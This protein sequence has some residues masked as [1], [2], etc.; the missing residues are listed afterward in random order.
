MNMDEKINKLNSLFIG[1][2]SKVNIVD[3]KKV[4]AVNFDNAATT[5]PF[6][7]VLESIIGLSDY[8]GSIGRGAG[9][10]AEITTR[11]YYES[12]NYIMDFF[13]IK[14][15]DKYT[16]IYV[17]N[18]TSGINSLSRILKHNKDDIILA[19]RMEHHSNDLPW[20]RRWK[21]DYV[22][23]DELGRLRVEDVEKKLICHKGK[24]KYVT[25]TGASN[26]TGYVNDIYSIA[27]IAHKY[28]AKII[29]DGAQL[30]PH[31][32]VDIWGASEE[33][34]IDYLV[35]SG[36]KIYAPFGGGVIIGAKE[37]FTKTMPDNEGGGTVKFVMDNDIEYLDIP[38]KEEAGTPNFFGAI[39]I[40][41]ALSSLEEIGFENIHKNEGKLRDK[42]LDG[43]KSIP[44]IINYGDVINKDDRLGIGIFNIEAI[45]HQ[46][47]AEILAK[48]YGIS[49]RQGWF[50]A[51]PYCRRLMHISET[52][53]SGFIRDDNEKMPGMI[54]VSFGV[55]N[56]EAE[57]DYFLECV[58][59][60]VKKSK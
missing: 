36:H 1:I 28:R 35:F 55:Y 15:K 56:E 50:C 52:S 11:L 43:L 4:R 18:T 33:E 26:V 14:D 45:Y 31:L 6:K 13:N 59:R 2:D 20:R 47:V 10:K 30:I 25:V 24:V 7:S 3:G 46:D 22:E 42:L 37:E 51:H 17:N 16:V 57:V 38:E 19:T 40:S 34:R 9:H 48:Y 32:K 8:Y 29:V 53:A 54:R 58:E 12:K 60:I 44:R 27:K 21:V 39:A 41:R 49:V 5:P 23:V